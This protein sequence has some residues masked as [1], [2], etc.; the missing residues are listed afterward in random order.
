MSDAVPRVRMFAGPNGSGKTTVKNALQR[1]AAWFGLYINPD[2]L[3]QA[4]RAGG[5]LPLGPLDLAATTEEVRAHFGSSPLLRAHGLHQSAGAI[6]GRDA[7]IDFGGLAFNAYHASVLADFLRRKALDAGK[8]FTFETVM[9]S[10]DKVDLLREAR[11]RGYRTYLYFIATEDP[12]INVQRVRNRV[13]EGGHDVPEEKIVARYYRSLA[14]LP[15][16]IRHTNRAYL[17]DTSEEHARYLAEITDGTRIDLKVDEI[18]H[19]FEP[20]WDQFGPKAS[21]PVS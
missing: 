13:A 20:T 2:E 5:V 15:A 17:F 16:A 7:G 6:V 12:A 1:P 21:G 8:S 19:W 10:P 18:P 9:S 3:E 11:G 4:I 14:L